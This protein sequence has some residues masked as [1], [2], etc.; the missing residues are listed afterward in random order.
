MSCLA[1][2]LQNLFLSE[3]RDYSTALLG[4]A[5]VIKNI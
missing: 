3:A 1:T 5:S 2:P 4:I